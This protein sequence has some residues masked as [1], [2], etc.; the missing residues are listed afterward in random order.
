MATFFGSSSVAPGITPAIVGTGWTRTSAG[1]VRKALVAVDSSTATSFA[2]SAQASVHSSC[3]GQWMYGPLAAQTISGTLAASV[4]GKAGTFGNIYET[5]IAAW[6]ATSAGALRGSL[7][8]KTND[9]NHINW[10]T[11]FGAYAVAAQTL[12]SVSAQAGDYLILE[13]G[14]DDPA[15]TN[16]EIGTLQAGGSKTSFTLS[17]S[18]QLF[19]PPPSPNVLWLGKPQPKRS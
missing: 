11:V 6:I 5:A 10:G 1:I 13:A 9:P 7:L 19:N 15:F 12:A 14:L 4:T 17:Q 8:S 18:I 3:L 16:S 2:D